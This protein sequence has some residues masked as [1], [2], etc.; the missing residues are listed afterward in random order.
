MQLAAQRSRFQASPSYITA[1]GYALAAIRA[2]ESWDIG[3]IE[4]S[5][6]L[7]ELEGWL[8]GAMAQPTRDES[9]E[10]M[11]IGSSL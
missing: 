7:R 10:H 1:K 3:K 2:Y 5:E 6:I 4:L 11:D 8:K 9:N